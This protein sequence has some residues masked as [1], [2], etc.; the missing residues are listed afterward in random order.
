MS[1]ISLYVKLKRVVSMFLDAND[2]S[3]GDFDKAWIIA[4][5]GMTTMGFSAEWEAKTV[6]LPVNGN[7]TVTF[8]SDYIM[9]NRIGVMNASGEISTLKIN[10]SLTTFKD[11]NPNRIAQIYPDI[12]TLDLNGVIINPFYLG[13]Y[14]GN[15]YGPLFGLGNGLVQYGDIRIDE[16]NGLIVLSPQYPYNDIML[17]YVN[18][19][20]KDEDYQV[21]TCLQEALIAFLE[22]KFKLGTEPAFY[23]RFREGRRSL[24]KKRVTL[25]QLNQ[26]IRETHGFKVKN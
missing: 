7:L 15:W 12:P 9:W 14:F 24:P 3:M 1:D 19:P 17:E 18:C 16:K 20:Q 23:A 8:P 26:V 4:F 11:N 10:D 2:K 13:Y 25:Q 5:R 22:W 6:R 21:H